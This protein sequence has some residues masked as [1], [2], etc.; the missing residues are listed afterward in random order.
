LIN[1]YKIVYSSDSELSATMNFT[2]EKYDILIAEDLATS[3]FVFMRRL[4]T[5]NISNIHKIK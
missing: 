3:S 4:D 1:R 5:K 2:E